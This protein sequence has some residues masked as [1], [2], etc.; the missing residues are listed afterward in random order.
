M[1]KLFLTGLVALL[2]PAALLAQSTTQSATRSAAADRAAGVITKQDYLWRVGVISAD[3][4]RGRNTPSPELDQTAEWIASEFARMGLRG[5]LADGS[6]IQRYPLEETTV[7]TAASKLTASDGTVLSFGED[8]VAG[9]RGGGGAADASGEFVV[10]SGSPESGV[11]LDPATL[12]GKHVVLLVG[13]GN[14]RALRPILTALRTAAP[15]SILTVGGG[16]DAQWASLAARGMRPSV[17]QVSEDGA[18][19]AAAGIPML[20]VRAASL[21]RLLGAHGVALAALQARADEPLRVDRVPDLSATLT[22]R[23][24]GRPASAPNVVAILDGSDPVL[25]NEYVLFSGH[26]DHLGVGAPDATGDSIFN[27]ADDDASGT[28]SVMEVARAMV[29]LPVRPK[30]ST[31]FLA[32]S[33]EE[34][35]LWGSS[36]FAD[37][38]AAPIDRIVADLNSDMVGRNW[39]DTIVAIGKEHSDLGATLNR[40]NAEHP[41]LD[42]TAIDDRWPEQNFYRRSDHFNFARKGV[43][44]LFFFNGT[45]EDYHRVSDEV[46]KIDGDKAARISKLI[47]YL[48]LDVANA[49]QRPRWNPESYKEIV[50]GGF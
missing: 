50:T 22:I 24:D 46:S 40:V 14:F 1:K 38:P 28:V 8:F 20:Q 41:E 12:A 17:R 39:P 9:G 6:F 29:A 23:T 10:V 43:P 27:G 47:F 3:S 13:G 35:G 21:S 36:Y 19:G 4:M 33:G 42:M 30:R 37:H 48:G 45:H 49:A 16:D 18:S 31:I 5:G 44:I 7:D 25:K 26:M 34:K 11:D 32:V 15:A 2:A